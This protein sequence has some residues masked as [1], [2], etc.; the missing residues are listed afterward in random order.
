M[1]LLGGP[2]ISIEMPIDWTP[3]ITLLIR[4]RNREKK[5]DKE[6]EINC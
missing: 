6:M 5:K 3:L 1:E 2:A 4:S